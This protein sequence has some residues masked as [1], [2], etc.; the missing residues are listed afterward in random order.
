MYWLTFHERK[1]PDDNIVTIFAEGWNAEVVVHLRELKVRQEAEVHWPLRWETRM[2]IAT[3]TEQVTER[4][5]S[6][7]ERYINRNTLVQQAV[8]NPRHALLHLSNLYSG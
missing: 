8:R 3:N 5:P 1:E 4:W 6:V 7:T 2:V